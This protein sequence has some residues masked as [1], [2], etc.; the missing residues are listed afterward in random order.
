M[1]GGGDYFGHR[2]FAVVGSSVTRLEVCI[3]SYFKDTN[4]MPESQVLEGSILRI[5]NTSSELDPIK[6]ECR[7]AYSDLES[8]PKHFGQ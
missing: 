4:F 5:L 2:T 8:I 7:K 6:G 1:G 3:F